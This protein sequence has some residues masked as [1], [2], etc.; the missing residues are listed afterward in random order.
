MDAQL[1]LKEGAIDLIRRLSGLKTESAI[2]GSFG[3][4]YDAWN[5]I[6]AGQ[7]AP[8]PSFV[9]GVTL[10][11]GIPIDSFV[12]AVEKKALAA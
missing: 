6:K 11:L 10:A 3:V 8:S 1:K 7:Q 12:E 5:K 4:S 9:A 2:A